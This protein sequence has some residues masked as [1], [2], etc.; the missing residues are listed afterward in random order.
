MGHSAL[1]IKDEELMLNHW[2]SKRRTICEVLREINDI[3]IDSPDY[4]L[5]VPFLLEATLMA[6]KMDR[7][8][9]EYKN[10]WDKKLYKKN[11]DYDLDIKRRGMRRG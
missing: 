11:M 6:K 5:I 7:K 3:L 4:H 1:P 10:D 8:L 9:R 2:V